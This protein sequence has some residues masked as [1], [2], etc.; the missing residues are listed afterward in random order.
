MRLLPLFVRKHLARRAMRHPV[1]AWA[2]IVVRLLDLAFF[3]LFL[4]VCVI[5]HT[6]G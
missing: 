6:T 3:G 2:D 5:A 1:T 4:L